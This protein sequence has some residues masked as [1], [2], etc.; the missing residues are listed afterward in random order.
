VSHSFTQNL[1]DR[2]VE[3]FLRVH[4]ETINHEEADLYLASMATLYSAFSCGTRFPLNSGETRFPKETYRNTSTP[5]VGVKVEAREA[6]TTLT[7]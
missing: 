6:R 1:R 2:L 5:R 7:P 4:G 3:Y